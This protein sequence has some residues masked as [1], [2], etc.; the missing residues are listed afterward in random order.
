M[1]V[2]TVGSAGPA[3]TGLSRS[4]RL[5]GFGVA[6]AGV[7]AV[8]ALLLPIRDRVG[9]ETVLL[10]Q[11]LICVAASAV[12]GV[13][14]ATVAAGAGFLAANYF[15]TAPYGSLFVQ[16]QSQVWDLV[17]FLTVAVGVGIIVEVGARH[18]ARAERSRLE[19][20]AVT[21]LGRREYGADTVATLLHDIHDNL[22]MERVAL[23]S[24]RSELVGVGE[25]EG[26]KVST[27]IPAG[28]DLELVLY[29][30]ELL[31]TDP[32]L[33]E[34]LGA[35]A[36]RLWRSELV[37]AEAA[38]AEELA[39]TDQLRASLLAAVGHDLRT[40]LAAVKASVS[41][42]R[43]DDVELDPADVRE[44][45]D[46]IETNADRLGHLIANLLDMS[47]LQAGVMSVHLEPVAVDEVLEEALR[48]AGERVEFDLPDDLP[49]VMAD[50]GL[51]ERV[52]EN[53]V[54]NAERHLP[55]DGKVLIRAR[56]AAAGV[57]VAVVDS[58][59]GM[60][61]AQFDAMFQ[62]FQHFDDR[63]HGGVGLG[64]AIA[65]GFVEAQ[66]GTIVPSETRGGGLTMTVTL[67]A[68]R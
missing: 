25:S 40:P 52:F 34:A 59:P 7:V 61:S 20:D 63:S 47:R 27:R 33:L 15:F 43:Q 48:R 22:A 26:S 8:T 9:L 11:V 50:A 49:L 66:G 58:G 53:L 45:L 18:R 38:K 46:V 6:A 13:V 21:E 41:T 10:L 56:R 44:L 35:T 2:I 16:H 39:R 54:D 24:G 37:A 64:L 17:A 42:L 51:L 4:R 60:P 36:G 14:P 30:P 23:V 62:P 65:R 29:G 5:A 19:A 12:G 68:A 1:S 3:L 32:R 57:S 67:E 28:G 55:E 31:G